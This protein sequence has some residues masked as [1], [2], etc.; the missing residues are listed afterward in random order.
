MAACVARFDDVRVI[1]ARFSR[2][3]IVTRATITTPV[4]LG[5][6]AEIVVPTARE[7]V[8]VDDS[9]LRVP[10][11]CVL[12]CRAD[13]QKR[14]TAPGRTQITRFQLSDRLAERLRDCLAREVVVVRSDRLGD[15]IPILMREGRG[16]DEF[17][18]LV[19]EGAIRLAYVFARRVS[20][21]SR[22]SGRL[23]SRELARVHEYTMRHLSESISVE[24]LASIAGMSQRG[25]TDRFA[26]EIG[27]SPLAYVRRLRLAE[28]ERMLRQTNLAV[29]E[30]AHQCGFYDHA[31][32]TRTFRS[33]TGMT[34]ME[35]R[36]TTRR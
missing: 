4:V 5:G 34:P 25:L 2:D 1:G 3:V 36:R 33:H 24:S 23:Y 30:I 21:R 7:L 13:F 18:P 10:V 20:V 12:L 11:G 19:L 27:V 26:R 32:L 31:H 22:A 9:S 29:S 35:F 15:S 16:V 28:V 17:S 8:A 6:R 14:F